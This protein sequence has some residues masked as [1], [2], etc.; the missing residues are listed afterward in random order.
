MKDLVFVL[1]MLKRNPL[2]LAVNVT[3]LGLAFSTLLLTMVLVTYELSYDNFFPTKDRVVRLYNKA[4][5][6][7]ST[8]IY[9]IGLREAYTQIPANVPDIEAATQIYRGWKVM[10]ESGQQKFDGLELLYADKEFFQVFGLNLDYGNSRDALQGEKKIVL[11]K[12]TALKLFSRL[13][14][15]GEVVK[16]HDDSY[17]ITGVINDLPKNCHFD[18]DVLIS[19][20]TIHPEDFG[21]L[22]FFT[23][24]LLTT[25]ADKLLAA[26]KIASMNN[27]VMEKWASYTNS[28]V[29][30]GVE[31]L[32]RIYMHSIAKD[33]ISSRGNFSQIMLVSLIA[34]FVLLIA[35]ISFINLCIIQG[36]KRIAEIATRKMFGARNANIANIFFLETAIVFLLSFLLA[37]F[38]TYLTLPE[39]AVMLRS[40]VGLSDLLSARSISLI[41]GVMGFLFLVSTG[42]PVLYLSRLD[43][44]L[45]MRGRK[46]H[47]RSKFQLSAIT[48]LVQFMITAF[49]ISSIVI[50][51]A[52]VKYLKN[53]PLEFETGNVR[54]FDGFGSGIQNKYASLKA[55]L[56]KLPFIEEVGGSDHSMG[57]GC[58]GEYIKTAG[59]PENANKDINEYRVLPGFCET[60]KLHLTGGRFFN[61][62]EKDKSAVILNESAVRML[63]IDDPVG[64][65]IDYNNEGKYEIIGVVK[66]FY[67]MSGPESSVSPLSLTNYRDRLRVLYIKSIRPLTQ[68]QL[69]Q[70]KVIL[71]GYD[72]EYMLNTFE[73]KDIYEKKFQNENRL[74]KMVSIGTFE[75]ILIS[76]IGLMA[77]SILNVA[78]KTR[79]IGIRKVMGSSVQEI[80]WNLLI[81]TM[82]IV[83]IAMSLAF[84]AGYF[85][86]HQWLNTFVNK[87]NLHPGYFA[88][89]ALL[90]FSVAIMATIGQSWHAATRNPV[91][92]VKHE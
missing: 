50:M 59:S 85:V 61:D 39:F 84:I 14:C 66:D 76:L 4:T 36:E 69:T 63:G 17:T 75:V 73:L 51:L 48:V 81:E 78:R 54:G 31:P 26:T 19:M 13:D 77:L 30:S 20:P 47:R 25:K 38:I 55:E 91:D 33:A 29:E 6:N 10:L 11:S 58:S 74:L 79:E 44:V 37:V 43:L 7:T 68:S 32:N 46:S 49:F 57:G 71:R 41:T 28:R 89:S 23:Y 8:D 83:L 80:I 86:M 9:A 64:K 70:V 3:G 18:F 65:V 16:M 21:G 60:M 87:I 62:S 15:I 67:Y 52:Q 2:F 22:E 45:G 5:D 1:R 12:S 88:I 72:P 35:I 42:Y 92:A 82:V 40:K 24:F 56:E 90:T 53:I 27:K 34:V